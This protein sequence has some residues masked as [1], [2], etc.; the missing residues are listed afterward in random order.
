MN[1][2]I[3]LFQSSAVDRYQ[4]CQFQS[5]AFDS[6]TLQIFDTRNALLDDICMNGVA[7]VLQALFVRDPSRGVFAERCAIFSTHDLNRIRYKAPDADL[8]RSTYQKEFWLK[9]T[10]IL[11]IHRP[12][13]CHWVL[14]V[15]YLPCKEVHLF[16]SFASISSWKRDIEV[17]SLNSRL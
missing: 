9:D 12:S 4:N 14:A 10:W 2:D 13:D 7:A 11:P 16:D 1:R 5:F 3:P 8:W 6:K 15:I 17:M